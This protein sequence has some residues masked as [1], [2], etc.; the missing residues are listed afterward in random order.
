MSLLCAVC[1]RSFGDESRREV[2]CVCRSCK[3]ELR[4]ARDLG[5][6]PAAVSAESRARTATEPPR[7]GG[8]SPKGS[9]VAGRVWPT[10]LEVAGR[11]VI[12]A[13]FSPAS[14]GSHVDDD[15]G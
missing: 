5:V 13:S 9:E 7:S 4:L 15:Y 14:D 1:W 2:F 12:D 6:L 11:T 3:S 8:E 10:A